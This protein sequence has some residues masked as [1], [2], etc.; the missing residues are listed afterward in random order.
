[1]ALILR[2]QIGRKLTATE[3][4]GNFTYLES[5]SG[6]TSSQGGISFPYVGTS[7]FIG[8]M[9]ITG[10][11]NVTYDTDFNF[12][13][14]DNY[15]IDAI[16]QYTGIGG[17]WSA[18]TYSGS[19]FGN[20]LDDGTQF[21]AFGLLDGVAVNTDLGV[22]L[23]S[24]GVGSFFTSDES[25]VS[26]S[27][28]Q[29]DRTSIGG[30]VFTTLS[31]DST[32]K[33]GTQS[34]TQSEYV[35]YNFIILKDEDNGTSDMTIQKTNNLGEV[36]GFG[37]G[38]YV[39]GFNM[40]SEL[41]DID[42]EILTIRNNQF[43]SVFEVK[44][45]EINV[46]VPFNITSNGLSFSTTQLNLQD[47]ARVFVESPPP[48]PGFWATASFT[49][50]FMGFQL[51]DGNAQFYTGIIE[52]GAYDLGLATTSYY[53]IGEYLI[54]PSFSFGGGF[55]STNNTYQ[56]QIY[57]SFQTGLGPESYAFYML[58]NNEE[59]YLE[60][61]KINSL[62][63]QVNLKL[64]HDSEG[65][66]ILSELSDNN[67]NIFQVQNNQ[68]D[69]VFEITHQEIRFGASASIIT[70]GATG[71][72]GTYSTGAGQVVTVTNGIITDVS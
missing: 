10:G 58:E 7:S 38:D 36:V 22:T 3:L 23:P 44:H 16:K 9:D 24:K 69:N 26:I 68:F 43:D 71:F 25:L 54:S 72:S 33:S 13:S 55:I 12:V 64:D 4:D 52:N 49:G 41:S 62:G 67:S 34:G 17:G 18:F 2:N 30:N 47:A 29:Q 40:V 32:F 60:L 15:V 50:D 51:D 6:G 48:F 59:P 61:S 14:N 42:S 8:D 46:N 56:Y 66:V 57:G 21:S 37:I 27:L 11:L 28:L 1:M 19:F 45:Q 39:N 31:I 53:G 5:I 70:G 20:V 65:V 63:E 35:K